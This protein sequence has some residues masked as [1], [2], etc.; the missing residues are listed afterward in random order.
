METCSDPITGPGVDTAGP[1]ASGPR[2]WERFE[3]WTQRWEALRES[4]DSEW[5]AAFEA[6]TTPGSDSARKWLGWA[7]YRLAARVNPEIHD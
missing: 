7:L 2:R 6:F 3:E 1:A 4:V 5:N